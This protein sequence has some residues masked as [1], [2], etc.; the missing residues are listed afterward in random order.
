MFLNP[1]SFGGISILGNPETVP[2]SFIQLTNVFCTNT[3]GFK[4]EAAIWER[5]LLAEP[6]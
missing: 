5:K 6:V 4:P 3:R 2:C 1:V